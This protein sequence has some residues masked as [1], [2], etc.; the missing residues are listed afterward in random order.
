MSQIPGRP[1]PTVTA[2]NE[3]F[4]TAG[5]DGVLRIQECRSCD[6]LIHP[7]QPICRYCRSHDLGV[8]DVSGRAT[9]AGFTVNER[10]DSPICHRR[11][12][13]PRLRSSRIRGSG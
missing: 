5:R 8:R 3:Y 10:F 2:L 1:L 9:L 4:W 12:W 7:P 6:A 11:T 13:W